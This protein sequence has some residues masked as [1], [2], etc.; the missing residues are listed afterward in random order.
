MTADEVHDIIATVGGVDMNELAL[1]NSLFN[2]SLMDDALNFNY[3]N[4]LAPKVDITEDAN[5]YT[6]SMELPGRTQNDVNIE[7]NAGTLTISSKD[8]EQK[9]EKEMKYLVRE[10]RAVSFSR[11]FSLPD[12]VSEDET[13]ASFKNGILTVTLK[14][15]AAPEPKK[16]SIKCED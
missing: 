11:S 4:V 8:E 2:N 15:R 9:E 5:A 10:R 6:L 16:I 1:F 12:D 7:I 14:R 13:A 3:K